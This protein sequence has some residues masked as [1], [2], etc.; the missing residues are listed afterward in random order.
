MYN[1]H[2]ESFRVINQCSNYDKLVDLNPVSVSKQYDEY[3]IFSSA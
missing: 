1:V 3:N 2:G